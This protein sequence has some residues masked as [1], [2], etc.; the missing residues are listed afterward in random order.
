MK[1]GNDSQALAKAS[2]AGP[3][4]PL[5]ENAASVAQITFQRQEQEADRPVL[6]EATLSLV[7]KADV[8][9]SQTLLLGSINKT[10]AAQMAVNETSAPLSC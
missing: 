2:A 10:A 8:A 5:A 7:Q 6:L 1:R 4:A 9:G 3:L